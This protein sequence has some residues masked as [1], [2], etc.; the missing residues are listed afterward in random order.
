MSVSG[1]LWK[2]PIICRGAGRDRDPLLEIISTQSEDWSVVGL[3]L[4]CRLPGPARSRDSPRLSGT[5]IFKAFS[6]TKGFQSSPS[7]QQ[8]RRPCSLPLRQTSWS[9][10]KVSPHW[11]H[12]ASLPGWEIIL[13]TGLWKTRPAGLTGSAGLPQVSASPPLQGLVVSSVK[14][15][16]PCFFSASPEKDGLGNR[17]TKALPVAELSSWPH[18]WEAGSLSF[19][20]NA[21]FL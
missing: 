11:L 5:I 18:S 20:E 10:S 3:G 9:F 2:L 6:K 8:A 4:V 14:C 19:A 16:A 13:A 21:Y 7:L 1:C 17:P 12:V 15:G